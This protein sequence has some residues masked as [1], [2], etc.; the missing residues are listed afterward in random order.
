MDLFFL[1]GKSCGMFVVTGV[2]SS[3]AVLLATTSQFPRKRYHPPTITAASI[4]S[5]SSLI[6]SSE[7]KHP[8]I[9]VTDEEKFAHSR[10]QSHHSIHPFTFPKLAHLLVRH[11]FLTSHHS[12]KSLPFFLTGKSCGMFVVTG[13][14]SSLA[15]LL[16]TTSQFPG[17]LKVIIFLLVLCACG[18]VLIA[19]GVPEPSSD[20]RDPRAAPVR[21]LFLV[22]DSIR[23][24]ASDDQGVPDQATKDVCDP[25]E[26]TR[27]I[28]V[29]V[30]FV[31]SSRLNS[32]GGPIQQSSKVKSSRPRSASAQ[33]VPDPSS[34]VRDPR[35]APAR[36][37]FLV[38]DSIRQLASDDQ[39]VPDQATKDVRDP[40]EAT[41]SIPARVPFV[42]SSRLNSFG[43][44][45]QQSS[46]VKSSRPRS[47]S[48]QGVPDPSSDVRDPRAAPA[49]D[50][51][52]VRDSIRQ[53]ASDDQG[54]PDQATKDVR[55]P[56][57]ATRSIPARVPF[58]SS[59]RLNSFG[60][61][62]QQSS[63]VKR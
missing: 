52:L 19:Q 24:L 51:F 30:P 8:L 33:G 47:A 31:S 11:R 34:D 4:S 23:Q 28:P 63:K 54:V 17:K 55:D 14:G 5:P 58:V 53:L 48:A 42:S 10:L 21:D 41:R 43:G 22:R 62:I 61:P 38:R 3:L 35:A 60:G 13:V 7:L 59:S 46:K 36:D 15:V 26:A 20:I 37:L 57:E 2:G 12:S 1:T 18:N 50:L 32:F 39:G 6:A 49:R 29:R 16:A 27:Y 9:D 25:I 45:I 44:P 40:I 56:I